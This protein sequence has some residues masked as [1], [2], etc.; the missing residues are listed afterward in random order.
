MRIPLFPPTLLPPTLK[1]SSGDH[2]P[3]GQVGLDGRG[4]CWEKG[5]VWPSRGQASWTR[6]F[7]LHPP[8]LHGPVV[9]LL[10]FPATPMMHFTPLPAFLWCLFLHHCPLSFWHKFRS[11]ILSSSPFFSLFLSLQNW[12]PFWPW[13]FS[14]TLTLL[15][16]H[17]KH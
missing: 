7:V 2:R 12:L 9:L 15:F 16:P 14:L 11:Y 10:Q 13:P 5:G 3:S 6:F 1:L 4:R 8:F 17:L